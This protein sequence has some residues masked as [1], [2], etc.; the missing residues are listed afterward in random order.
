MTG[1]YTPAW[2]IVALLAGAAP[3][4]QARP[5]QLDRVVV[6][7]RH[8]VR[9]PTKPAPLP[10]AM[11][12]D[13]WPTWDV[14]WGELTGHGARAVGLLGDFDRAR[15]RALLGPG[16]PAVRVVADIDERTLH[17][18]AA[19]A[20]H[21]V[22]GCAIAVEHGP[23][24]QPDPRFSPFEAR[25]ALTEAEALAAA[26]AALPAG[27]TAALD[28]Q[29]ADQWRTIDAVTGCTAP[30][31]SITARPTTL[32]APGGR[33]KLSGALGKGASFAQTLALEYADGKPMAEVG[34]GR[35][36]RAQITDLSAL[37]A[38]EF[39]I[40]A[41]PPALA[42]AG[43]AALLAEARAALTGTDAPRYAV[44]VGHDSNL[45]WL[46]GALGVHWQ[47][48]QFARDDPPPGGALVFERWTNHAGR[49]RLRI[50]FRS[51]TL[52]EMRNLTP[53][54]H[55]ETPV[56]GFTACA[57]PAG[58]SLAELSAAL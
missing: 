31:C 19:Y 35:A 41:R 15:Y 3:V 53:I 57:G 22:P 23:A 4:A 7:M 37:H 48:P 34:W 46:G 52:D 58:C 51:Q 39:A 32:S 27:G 18:A 21:L 10:A 11:V 12:R 44:F 26:Q 33:A 28:A 20:A 55:A 43:A 2:L 9:P 25:S 56:T 1:W 30:A 29:L 14:G 36:T 50:R 42:R 45:S 54:G 49:Y 8:G 13:T 24:G 47:V 40:T 5:W 16:C 38:A 17:T 6:V